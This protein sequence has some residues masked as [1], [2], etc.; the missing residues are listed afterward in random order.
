MTEIA[1]EFVTYQKE[2]MIA[3][4]SRYI[5]KNEKSKDYG[6]EV[7]YLTYLDFW[8]PAGFK[9]TSEDFKKFYWFTPWEWRESVKNALGKKVQIRTVVCPL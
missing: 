5:S 3:D 2:V 6:K 8:K 7:I 1:K 4:C 9:M